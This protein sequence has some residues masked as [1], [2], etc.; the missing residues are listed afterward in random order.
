[1]HSSGQP[2]IKYLGCLTKFKVASDRAA[3][4]PVGEDGIGLGE[5]FGDQSLNRGKNA[6]VSVVAELEVLAHDWNRCRSGEQYQS[7]CRSDQARSSLL[8][9]AD[10]YDG[11][12]GVR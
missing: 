12:A 5:V 9:T 11:Y 6:F 10:R 1:M 3:L 7:Q 8:G 4:I 2:W